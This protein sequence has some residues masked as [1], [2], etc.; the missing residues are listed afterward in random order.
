MNLL[1]VLVIVGI[2]SAAL[3]GYRV[4]LLARAA[5]WAGLAVGFYVGLRMVPTALRTFT[6]PNASSRLLVA[7]TVLIL[8]TFLGQ[9]L[10]LLFGHRLRGVLPIGGARTADRVLGSVAGALS[11]VVALWLF[12]PTLTDVPG[13]AAEQSRN[14]VVARAVSAVFPSPPDATRVVR[15][16]VDERSFPRVFSGIAPAPNAGIPP[17]A[18]PLTSELVDAVIKSTV[19]IQGEACR[20]IQEGSG[21]VV[22]DDVIVTNAHV[23]AGEPKVEVIRPDGKHLP[24]EVAVFDPARDLAV[25]HVDR[26]GMPSLARANGAR[27]AEGAVFGHPGGEE[28]VRAAPARISDEVTA[29]GEDIYGQPTKRQVFILAAELKPGD[30]GAA[31]VDTGGRVMG[32]AFA[33]APDRPGTAYALTHVELDS[34]LRTYGANPSQRTDTQRCVA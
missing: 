21:F 7:V 19:K 16:L 18:V 4:G 27:G 6:L 33:I 25:L 20:R 2:V 13:W 3:G 17:P 1:D 12:L 28:Q 5:S 22:S 24:A 23:V 11:V 26:L 10:G 15:R 31:L 9:A 34:V 30:S 14:S 29:E 8:G 32:V